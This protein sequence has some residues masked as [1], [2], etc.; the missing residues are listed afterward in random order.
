MP[1]APA[2]RG[3]VV[4]VKSNPRGEFGIDGWRV[5]VTVMH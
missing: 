3:K 1:E 2:A 4:T 5:T